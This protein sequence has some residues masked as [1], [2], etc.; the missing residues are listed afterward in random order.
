MS[1]RFDFFNSLLEFH[2]TEE[3]L[4]IKKEKGLECW[5]VY[6]ILLTYIKK[7]KGLSIKERDY[8][9]FLN[10]ALTATLIKKETLTE[11]LDY[12]KEKGIVYLVQ[13]KLY[14]PEL[15]NYIENLSEQKRKA[16]AKRW[17]NALAKE[18][19]LEVNTLPDSDIFKK[20][21]ELK[22][23]VKFN[24]LNELTLKQIVNYYPVEVLEYFYS[25]L[26][27]F[28]KSAKASSQKAPFNTGEWELLS[29]LLNCYN[30]RIELKKQLPAIVLE[31]SFGNTWT[32]PGSTESQKP[33]RQ[34]FPEHTPENWKKFWW[35]NWSSD[36]WDWW[37]FL[38]DTAK[39]GFQ[40]RLERSKEDRKRFFSIYTAQE[41]SNF[42]DK[43]FHPDTGLV[44][45]HTD[46]YAVW[47]HLDV[48]SLESYFWEKDGG[49]YEKP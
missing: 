49:Y 8:S 47:K 39:Q 12:L 34:Q 9:R 6:T 43:W 32:N 48:I 3:S 23:R 26:S 29:Y 13:D 11:H 19:E 22:I 10:D 42:F 4:Q 17:E 40:M 37:D 38:K 2:F 20:L 14:H 31:N 18:P 5:T 15:A 27:H 46:F 1:K 45:Q 16:A 36:S 41:W 21:L 35:V 28:D 30:A 33:Q 25:N 24:K 44:R 7:N